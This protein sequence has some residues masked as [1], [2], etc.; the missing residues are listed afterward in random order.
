MIK[1][2]PDK[3]YRREYHKKNKEKIAKQ[4][5]EYYKEK[6]QQSVNLPTFGSLKKGG[7]C[8]VYTDGFT[9]ELKPLVPKIVNKVLEDC[10]K[11][12]KK[13]LEEENE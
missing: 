2:M 11:N 6:G 8:I 3:E 13:Y 4:Q 10:I 5:K 9:K 7:K 12:P 1:G